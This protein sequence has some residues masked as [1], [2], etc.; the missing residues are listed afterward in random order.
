MTQGTIL[1]RTFANNNISGYIKTQTSSTIVNYSGISCIAN[2]I[3]YLNP[4]LRFDPETFQI[5]RKFTRHGTVHL[6]Q[7]ILSC[8]T[9]FTVGPNK[10]S[11]SRVLLEKLTVA[12]IVKKCPIFYGTIKY[13]NKSP[14]FVPILSQVN[15]ANSNTPHFFKTHFS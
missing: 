12:Q 2:L 9:V 6:M 1:K 15:S 8:S 4:E 7:F 14:S 13:V 3:T 5:R 11:W 10:V